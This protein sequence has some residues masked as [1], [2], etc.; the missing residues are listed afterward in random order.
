MSRGVDNGQRERVAWQQRADTSTGKLGYAGELFSSG[1]SLISCPSRGCIAKTTGARA[2]SSCPPASSKTASLP[3][4]AYC[5][6]QAFWYWVSFLHFAVRQEPFT[7]QG[8]LE[9]S[10]SYYSTRFALERSIAGVR[11][12][13]FASILYLPVLFA[14]L[15]LDKK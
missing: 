5:P 3:G 14:L 15:V 8:L 1:N 2:T 6:R 11:Q 7:L 10:F 12:L 13:L 4:S 9:A